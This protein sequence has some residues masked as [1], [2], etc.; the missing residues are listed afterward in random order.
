MDAECCHTTF[1]LLRGTKTAIEAGA[2]W[3]VRSHKIDY[4]HPASTL[5]FLSNLIFNL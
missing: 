2:I 4:L 3:V 5:S 1:Q